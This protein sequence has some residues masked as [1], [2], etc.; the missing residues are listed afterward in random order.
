MARLEI[1]ED[2]LRELFIRGSGKGG[3]KVQ[4]TSSCVQLLHVPTGIEVRC[5]KTRSQTL[6]RYYARVLLCEKIAEKIHGEKSKRKAAQEKIR[7]Q[8]QRRSRKQKAKIREEKEH[9]S[10]KKDLRKSVKRDDD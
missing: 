10:K 9:T 7:R 2:D 8:K 3:Q 1:S 6:N 5:E 4:K